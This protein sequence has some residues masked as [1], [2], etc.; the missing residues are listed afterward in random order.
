M[1]FGDGNLFALPAPRA[2]FDV[3][4]RYWRSVAGFESSLSQR[5]IPPWRCAP[6]SRPPK[7][8]SQ[9]VK[10]ARLPRSGIGELISRRGTVAAV[11]S[12]LLFLWV[13]GA[14]IRL[15]KIRSQVPSL[16]GVPALLRGA[17][18]PPF[19]SYI[20][21]TEYY[22]NGSMQSGRPTR[23]PSETLGSAARHSPRAGP[24]NTSS[25]I[26]LE[27]GDAK[28]MWVALQP[29]GARRVRSNHSMRG[30]TGH[31]PAPGDD[32]RRSSALQILCRLSRRLGRSS[33]IPM[34]ARANG[35]LDAQRLPILLRA[36]QPH[37]KAVGLE[38]RRRG[39]RCK[40]SA[41]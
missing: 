13:C 40:R 3:D 16:R 1:V 30:E 8:E 26:R 18:S 41:R 36:P 24:A 2:A 14:C 27:V 4:A 38:A 17:S 6:R 21:V 34:S 9:S 35:N 20:I 31:R 33:R 11:S 37:H 7:D 19:F 32:E 23:Q 15:G 22:D 5:G 39:P 28:R 12:P 10:D 29:E 25:A